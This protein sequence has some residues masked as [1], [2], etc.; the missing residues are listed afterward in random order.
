MGLIT[1]RETMRVYDLD[2]TGEIGRYD[3]RHEITFVAGMPTPE[4]LEN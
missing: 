2:V 3:E 4:V 1:R